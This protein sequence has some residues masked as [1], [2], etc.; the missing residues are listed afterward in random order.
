MADP[1]NKTTK[2]IKI[3]K[4][5]FVFLFLFRTSIT[6]NRYSLGSIQ[7]KHSQPSL[8]NTFYVKVEGTIAKKDKI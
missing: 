4:K 7:S 1:T 5:K 8:Q 6:S 2:D 3:N